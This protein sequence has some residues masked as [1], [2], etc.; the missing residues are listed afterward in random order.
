MAKIVVNREV[1]KGCKLCVD[2]C[3]KKT[4][5]V[6]ENANS[7]GYYPAILLDESKCIGCTMCALICPDVAIEVYK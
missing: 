3:P 4:I 7:S 5:G 2:E 6:D 1:C